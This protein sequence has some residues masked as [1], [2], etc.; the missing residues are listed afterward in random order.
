MPHAQI[1]GKE[2]P[3]QDVF[4]DKFVFRIPRYQRPYAWKVEQAQT[5]LEDLLGA[6]GDLNDS[7]D[8]L[9]SYFLGSI[10]IVKEEGQPDAEVVDGQ[11]RLTTLT[12]L[13]AAIRATY[14]DQD[15]RNNLTGFIYHKGNPLTKTPDHHHLTLRERD[16][17]FFQDVIQKDIALTKVR[18]LNIA[19]LPTDSQI[20]IV[21]NCRELLKKLALF[22]D[23]Q[24]NTL[25]SYILTQCYL[26]VVS[27]PT[28][29]SAYRIFSVLND[30]GLDL[31]HSDI[32]KAEL[33]GRIE[34]SLQEQ[35]SNRW[36]EAEDTIGREAFKDL[37]AHI[38]TIHRKAKLKETILKEVRQH[39]L[40]KYT[41]KD[42]ID[43]VVVPYTTAYDIIRTTSYQSTTDAQ[44]INSILS[45]LLR[46]DNFDW[47][48]PAL[49]G[50]NQLH[51][52]PDQWLPFLKDLERLAASLMIRRVNINIRIDRYA[53]VLSAMENGS[54]LYR[55]SSPLQLQ[56]DEIRETIERLNGDIYNSGPRVYIM[57]RL[58]AELSENGQTP[59][60]PIYT[61]EHV[62]P[63][64]PTENS[65]WMAWYPDVE[66][67]GSWLNRLGN[68]A[69][70]SKRKNSQAQN[71]EFDRKKKEYFNTPSTPF[72]L[73]TQILNR[74]TW[75]L[76]VLEAR[77][78]ENL[79]KLT[80]LWRLNLPDNSQ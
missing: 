36:E 26:I 23:D 5:L 66:V 10:V 9:E 68:L 18:T 17:E 60:L 6:I 20:N 2:Y 73:T 70:L 19:E 25:A 75:K 24:L 27:T 55:N 38:R 31:S 16:A 54:D 67:R 14:R 77:Q 76:D 33:V 52:S 39:V 41:P 56:V 22:N 43:K 42:F 21:E 63:Q 47:M 74:S 62:L 51:H 49:V 58:D 7:S 53:K 46:I 69:L 61:V 29:E 37:F 40:P 3:I 59:V 57:R 34:E 30:R 64:N 45:W 35:Y 78:K 1:H 80:Q 32:F 15:A 11:Q 72:A 48:P 8:D 13:L 71:F 4:C 65:Q 12:I 28:V 50:Y 79:G 44:E